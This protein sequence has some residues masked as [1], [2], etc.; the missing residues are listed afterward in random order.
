MRI[1]H[2]HEKIFNDKI[3]LKIVKSVFYLTLNFLDCPLYRLKVAQSPIDI[4]EALIG[5]VGD[6]FVLTASDRKCIRSIVIL[7]D[8][9]E[10]SRLLNDH[11]LLLYTGSAGDTVQFSDSMQ[12]KVQLYGI[13]KGRELSTSAA[14][15][16]IRKELAT[17]LRS[18]VRVFSLKKLLY[19]STTR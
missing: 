2:L 3:H 14:A 17:S 9:A 5:I 13:Q 7:K 15:A 1:F 16:F 4:M 10:K 18:K 6:G 12:R 8:D 19:Q 11:T